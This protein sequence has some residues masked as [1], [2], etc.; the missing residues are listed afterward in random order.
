MARELGVDIPSEAVEASKAVVDQVDLDSI[1]EREL[2]TR[3]D[4]KARVEEFSVLAGH[5]HAHKGM[6]SRDLTEN[7]EQLQIRDGLVL[8]RDRMVTALARLAE[9]ATEYEGAP[10]VDRIRVFL[11]RQH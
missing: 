5:Q 7:V 6:T 8:V 3:H 4:V 1:T 9:R 11:G 2:A 10:A